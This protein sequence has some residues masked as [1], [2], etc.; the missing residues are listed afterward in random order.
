MKTSER[1]SFTDL[2]FVSPIRGPLGRIRSGKGHLGVDIIAP[3]NTPIKACLS[4]TVIQAD[5]S[6]ENGHTI[7]IQHSN[8]LVSMYK[9]NSALLKK[10]DPVLKPERPLQLLEIPA[11]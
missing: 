4:G 11:P 5:W 3:K 7:A 9:H 2:N 8:N 1:E 10:Q 6:I